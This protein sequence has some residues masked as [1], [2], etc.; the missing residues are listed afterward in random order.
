MVFIYFIYF[1]FLFSCILQAML[2][3]VSLI[4]IVL[5]RNSSYQLAKIILH[6]QPTYFSHT[7][8]TLYICSY[9]Y[10]RA[11]TIEISK[12]LTKYSSRFLLF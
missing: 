8:N 1:S 11:E 12:V 3:C 6:V 5:I 4:I 2:W 9:R 10:T 7:L